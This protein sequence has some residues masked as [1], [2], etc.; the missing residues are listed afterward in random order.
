MSENIHQSV[1]ERLSKPIALIGMM[2]AGKSYLGR[3]LADRLEVPF[4]DSDQTVE[5]R[6]GQPVRDI[7]ENFGEEKFREAERNAILDLLHN[8]PCVIAMGGGA[9]TNPHTLADLKRESIMIWLCPDFE[10]LWQNVQKS[11][12]RPLLHTDNPEQTLRNLLEQRRDLYAQAHIHIP[13]LSR[14]QDKA[15]KEIVKALY[16][17]LNRDMV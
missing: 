2:G 5:E 9:I 11:E 17:F 10:T 15:M 1:K 8:R 14:S 16:E 13:T 3:A 4:Y 7:F 12:G 6:A